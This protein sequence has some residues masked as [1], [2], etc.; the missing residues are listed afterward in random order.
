[1]AEQQFDGKVAIVTGGASGIGAACSTTFARGGA[2]VV[3]ADLNEELGNGL[4][5]EIKAIGGDAIF[6]RT[7]V[8]RPE[9]VE[10]MV[11]AASNPSAGLTSRLTTPE[12]AVNRIQPAHIAS[13]VGAR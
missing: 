12:S 6:T 1:M 5:S 7:D 10:A 9:A 11:G 13:T 4:V 2:K 3:V 8:S